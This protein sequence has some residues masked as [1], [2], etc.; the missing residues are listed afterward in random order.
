MNILKNYNLISKILNVVGLVIFILAIS[1]Y[2]LKAD[3]FFNFTDESFY[4]LWAEQP[5]NFYGTTTHFGYLSNYIYRDLSYSIHAV[6]IFI[7]ITTALTLLFF[8]YNLKF[9][10]KKN[11]SKLNFLTN[12]FLFLVALS[13]LYIFNF[14]FVV[15]SY[16]WINYI[17]ILLVTIG[18]LRESGSVFVK[19]KI[20]LIQN[21]KN[22]IIISSGLFFIFFSKLSTYFIMNILIFS[23]FYIY[24]KNSLNRLLL[25]QIFS[26]CLIILFIYFHFGSFQNF[27][28]ITSYGFRH[29]SILAENRN[30]IGVVKSPLVS[31]F[32][33]LIFFIKNY[34]FVFLGTCFF[35]FFLFFISLFDKKI[36]DISILFV[37]LCFSI[38]G[39]PY[40]FYNFYLL[41]LIFITTLFIKKNIIFSKIYFKKNIVIIFFG[42]CLPFAFSFGTA[43]NIIYHSF[44]VSIFYLVAFFLIVISYYKNLKFILLFFTIFISISF[45]YNFKRSFLLPYGEKSTVT[46][47]SEVSILNR[48]QKI[49]VSEATATYIKEITKVLLA[50]NWKKDNYILDLTGISPGTIYVLQGKVLYFSWFNAYFKGASN[51]LASILK[52]GNRELIKSSWLITSDNKIYNL[53]INK[54]FHEIGINLYEDYIKILTLNYPLEPNTNFTFWKPKN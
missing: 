6:K 26:I 19:N 3:Y 50:N 12:T 32:T 1:I 52:E 2:L 28:N 39:L 27:V 14:F 40:W 37:L 25:I 54:L 45:F 34:F 35:T 16:N 48:D 46:I 24:T 30:I 38:L 4:L 36:T 11:F 41:I 21:I 18:L 31:L 33:G 17:G 5:G 47:F 23:W 8:C 29:E 51:F 49:K 13:G 20:F 7:I 42:F 9:F 43:N 22:V 53:S 10:L 15:L 44:Y